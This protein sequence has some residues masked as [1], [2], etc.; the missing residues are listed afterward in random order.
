M[1]RREHNAERD[2][3]LNAWLALQDAAAAPVGPIRSK[4]HHAEM[5]RLYDYLVAEVGE[6]RSHPLAGLLE[7]VVRL[8]KDYETENSPI[9]DCSPREALRYLME[10]NGLKQADLAKELGSQGV[11]SEILGG[12]REINARQA[13]ALARRFKVLPMC[14]V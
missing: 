3:L 4:Q 7:I 10:Q 9:A 14:F 1:L 13:R 2:R 12:K 8:I 11:V 5:L 6:T